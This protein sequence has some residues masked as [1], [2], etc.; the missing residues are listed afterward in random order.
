MPFVPTPNV[1]EAEMRMRLDTQKIENTLYFYK[2][3]GWTAA[4]V[5][6]V[7]NALLLWWTT[8]YSDPLSNTLTLNE[9][10]I[11]DLS[12][13]VGFA[14]EIPAPTPKPAGGSAEPSAPNNVALCVSFRTAGRGRSSRGRNY[15]PGIPKTAIA[16]N[17]VNTDTTTAIA[18]AYNDL[19][20]VADG[21]GGDWCVVSRF[22]GGSPRAAGL[23]SII[24]AATIV[25]S[26]VDSQRRRLPGRGQ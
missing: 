11:T 6:V 15:V 3:T 14:F 25:D 22:S 16:A 20:T 5:P 26:T 23:V 19:L 12:S 9:I 7:F 2:V 1:I 18:A 24:T 10:K 13:D 21:F 8:T 4:D 17:T